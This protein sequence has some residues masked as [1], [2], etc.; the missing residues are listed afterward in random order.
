MFTESPCFLCVAWP[1]LYG[2]GIARF[3]MFISTG[4]F[5]FPEQL[6][7]QPRDDIRGKKITK[8]H[9]YIVT[10][11]RRDLSVRR[12]K[13]GEKKVLFITQVFVSEM[14]GS[15]EIHM[16]FNFDEQKVL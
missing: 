2:V 15:Y 16:K 7:R 3:E 13:T 12:S 6:E 14:A 10:C 9:T 4:R 11:I 5:T 8:F 1:A